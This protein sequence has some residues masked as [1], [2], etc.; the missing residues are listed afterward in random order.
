MPLRP[1]PKPFKQ[2]G[3]LRGLEVPDGRLIKCADV[4]V[5]LI[6][7]EIP[8][9]Q[10]VEL[11]ETRAFVGQVNPHIQFFIVL[12]LNVTKHGVGGGRIANIDTE[13]SLRHLPGHGRSHKE[14][15]LRD[16]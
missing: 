11:V 16:R 8:K 14:I 1:R 6:V 2:I 9:G 5:Q 10:P 15:P 3:S 4:I 7:R 13:D 12:C